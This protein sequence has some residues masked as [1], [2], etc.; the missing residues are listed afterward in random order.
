M[1]LLHHPQNSSPRNSGEMGQICSFWGPMKGHLFWLEPLNC[2]GAMHF[3]PLSWPVA[4][5]WCPISQGGHTKA[6]TWGSY[7]GE[8][9][10]D[11]IPV[12]WAPG[13]PSSSQLAQMLLISR[14]GLDI[15]PSRN[16]HSTVGS[17]MVLGPGARGRQFTED[18]QELTRNPQV[19]VGYANSLWRWKRHNNQTFLN[20]NTFKLVDFRL[21]ILSA[22]AMPQT[23]FPDTWS[24]GHNHPS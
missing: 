2:H 6:T 15:R 17:S 21:I 23:G 24:A 5:C 1:S 10:I 19:L 22:L 3:S 11:D 7:H 9:P 20:S 4:F 8:A 16:Q 14:V 18:P 13:H 12:L